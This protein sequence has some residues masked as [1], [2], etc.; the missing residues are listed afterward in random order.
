MASKKNPN[1]LVVSKIAGR[2]RELPL[3][4]TKLD[5]EVRPSLDFDNLAWKLWKPTLLLMHKVVRKEKI[6]IKWVRIHSH[7]NLK[8]ELTHA[9]GFYDPEEK[10]IFL[11]HFDSETMLHELGHAKSS[12]YH[13]DPWAKA[14][15]KLYLKYLKGRT[16]TLGNGEPW[17][18]SIGTQGLSEVLWRKTAKIR[19]PEGDMASS[20]TL[21]VKDFCCLIN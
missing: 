13:G 15:A 2:Y 1:S 8:R 16:Q 4:A 6:T 9:M 5:F 17:S 3:W 10:G 18:I 14:T 19:V 12:G 11:C 21:S 20:Q 7:F